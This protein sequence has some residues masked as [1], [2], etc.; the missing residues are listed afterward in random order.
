MFLASCGEPSKQQKNIVL[1]SLVSQGR[2]P[3]IL[4]LLSPSEALFN[5]TEGRC[6]SRWSLT[7]GQPVSLLWHIYLGNQA[8]CI[9]TRLSN[10]TRAPVI[11]AAPMPRSR[12]S[13]IC[14][15]CVPPV[16]SPS[17]HLS[18]RRSVLSMPHIVE[19]LGK[20]EENPTLSG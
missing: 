8:H 10:I 18:S 9:T 11:Y 1:F 20:L 5:L 12:S 13:L 17:Q 2:Q 15:V 16:A 3:H 19:R 7:V 6:S 4:C 14:I